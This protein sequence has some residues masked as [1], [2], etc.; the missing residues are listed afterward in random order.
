MVSEEDVGEILV[1]I[2]AHV[3]YLPQ[4]PLQ[5]R[6]KSLEHAIGLWAIRCC[7]EVID[8]QLLEEFLSKI[9]AVVAQK[10]L[11]QAKSH[12]GVAHHLSINPSN[13]DS[14]R[15]ADAKIHQSQDVFVTTSSPW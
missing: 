11:W 8:L 14:F 6:V 3:S 4:H 10:F 1:P 12:Q 7:G 15:V 13:R 5:N 2:L 9:C